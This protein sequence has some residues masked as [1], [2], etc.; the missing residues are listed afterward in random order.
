[1]WD[2]P[3]IFSAKRISNGTLPDCEEIIFN[4]RNDLAVVQLPNPHL[5]N[6]VIDKKS[7]LPLSV[8]ADNRSMTTHA[9]NVNLHN[10]WNP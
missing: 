8:Y 6:C 7:T 1:M 5:N 2:H 10:K 3:Y 9:L 4:G